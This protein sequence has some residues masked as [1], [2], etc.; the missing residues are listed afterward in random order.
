MRAPRAH[1]RSRVDWPAPGVPEPTGTAPRPGVSNA[2]AADE[3][4]DRLATALNHLGVKH[5]SHARPARGGVPREPSELFER[6]FRSGDPRLQEAAVILLLTRP[7]F[8]GEA[9]AAI[10]SLDGPLRDRAMRRYV[11]AAAL[12]RMARTRIALALGP[13]P[14]IPPAYLDE[15]RL[16]PLDTDFGRDTLLA[17]AADEEA[18]YGYAAWRGYRALLDLFLAEIPRSGWGQPCGN[19]STERA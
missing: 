18:R 2:D 7:D 17:L 8:A 1:G 19:A 4:W 11:A 12:Q 14:D 16:P 6:L 10:R 15:L 5:V 3:E 9:R 13:Q